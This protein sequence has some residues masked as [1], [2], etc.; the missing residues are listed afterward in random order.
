MAFRK[1]TRQGGAAQLAALPGEVLFSVIHYFVRIT[2]GAVTIAAVVA[3]L[4][5]LRLAQGPIHLPWVASAAT[6]LVNRDAELVK[7]D[8]G[9]VI[10]T[11]GGAGNP[12]GIQ[13]VDVAIADRSGTPLFAIPRLAANFYSAD[14]IAGKIRPTRI[15]LIQPE[16]KLERLADGR[17]RVGLGPVAEDDDITAVTNSSFVNGG[18]PQAEAISRLL[19]GLSGDAE[20]LPELSRLRRISIIDA[21]LTFINETAGRRWHTRQADLTVQR[22]DS[23]LTA[24]LAIGLSDGSV[25][26]AQVSVDAVR[27]RGR[28][29]A[30]DVAVRFLNLRPEHLAEQI[31]AMQWLRLFDAPIDG[32]MTLTIHPDGVVENLEGRIASGPGRLLAGE[33][34]GRPF[35]RAELEFAYQPELRRMQ[36]PRL[37]LAS[38]AAETQMSGFVDLGFDAA[39][40]LTGMAAQLEVDRL[41]ITVPQVF[42]EP[43]HF[44]GGQV[45]A[46]LTLEPMRIE[47]AEANLRNGPLVFDVSGRAWV[48][49]D[50]WRTELRASGRHLT[51]AQLVQHWPLAAAKGAREWV[52][53]NIRGGDIDEAVALMRF[54]GGEPALNLDFAFSEIESSYLREMTPIRHGHGRGSLT[55]DT[56]DLAV[57]TGDVEPLAGAPLR[58][59]GSVVHLSNF[60]GKPTLSDIFLRVSGRS[61]GVL[62]LIDEAPLGFTTKLGLDPATVGGTAVVT[63]RLA[64]PLLKN[65]K[66]TDVAVSSAADLTDL[67]LPFRLRGSGPV[68]IRGKNVSLHATTEA[69]QLSG[70]LT[71]D[72]VGIELDWSEH[73][74]RG[75]DHRDIRIDGGVTPA[76]LASLG[77]EIDGFNDGRLPLKLELTQ[78][79]SDAFDF[80]LSGD[81]GPARIAIASLG[82]EKS[83]GAAG[84]IEAAGS[85]DG[86]VKL[87]KFALETDELGASGTMELDPEGKINTAKF[88]RIRYRDFA[89]I[90][91]SLTTGAG[92]GQSAKIG[93]RRLDL[94]LLDT[95]PEAGKG[96]SET[97][98]ADAR[99]PLQ[100]EF[101]VEEMVLRPELVARPA[102]GTFA[103]AADGTLAV[104]LG[105]QAGGSVPFVVDFRQATG[106]PGDLVLNSADAGGLLR[107]TGLF[108]G[109]QGGRLDLNAQV[110]HGDGLALSGIARITDVTVRE[111][112]TFSTILDEGGVSRAADAAQSGGLQF[113][114][115]KV[116]FG[117]RDGILTF[118]NATAKGNLLAVTLQGTVDQNTDDVDLAGVISPA[119]G[120]T[121]VLDNIPVL[122]KVLS[123][124]QGEGILAMTFA[125][126][127][128]REDPKFTVNPLSLLTPGI[129]RK[130]FSGRTNPPDERFLEQLKRDID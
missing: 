62:A 27:Q 49:P 6:R 24:R 68:E 92:G 36:V 37:S 26:G 43:L 106:Q 105:G 73:Y 67:R 99:E 41:H 19:D 77:I 54:G 121:G 108:A 13:F 110:A 42:A 5:Y 28:G 113:G 112:T 3:G 71:A 8:V 101:R 74:G 52:Q 111:A 120:L 47:L 123:G 53:K 122:G 94:A 75:R 1:R 119:Y 7:V 4:L 128:P 34:S 130:L 29:G 44:D 30:A 72:G 12:S 48:E 15:T 116:P 60:Q 79:G 39:G 117:F 14:L 70:P 21:D 80:T 22:L 115:V 78:K 35:E 31:D 16:A 33:A 91:A 102:T 98:A 125:V 104:H 55:L 25:A 85:L 63:T 118:D 69:M 97:D 86:G 82:W 18:T 46:R 90:S 64:F 95:L 100:I 17:F 10:L 83:E 57:D 58:I 84:R 51:A 32:G 87:S 127:G 65:L 66:M 59:D 45:V 107:A 114:K 56:F 129:L 109:A 81:V 103:R 40:T 96:G 76:L 89:D 23:G 20:I 2:F 38:K 93:G 126:K 11:L 88:D 61:D 124:G 50:G 9:D